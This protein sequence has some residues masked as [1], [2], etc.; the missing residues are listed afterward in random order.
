M[1]LLSS[2]DSVIQLTLDFLI[3]LTLQKNH[4]NYLKFFLI[5]ILLLFRI[6]G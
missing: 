4:N 2:L 1:H 3:N 6:K 5:L